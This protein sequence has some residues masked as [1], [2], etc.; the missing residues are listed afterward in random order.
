[1]RWRNWWAGSLGWASSWH[2][3][4]G[5]LAG[6]R[7]GLPR[8][9]MPSLLFRGDADGMLPLAEAGL[10]LHSDLGLTV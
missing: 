3:Y 5:W 7:N 2:F 1:M 8:V 6:F 4:R 10:G 9:D